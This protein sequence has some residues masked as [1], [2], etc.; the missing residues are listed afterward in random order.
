MND[1][2]TSPIYLSI[3]IPSYKSALVLQK[4]VSLLLKYL[5]QQSYSF[6]V[7]VVDDGSNDNGL[8]ES[9]AKKLNVSFLNRKLE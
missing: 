7:I 6:E 1:N 5:E 8:T 3:I 4:N 2:A 9:I